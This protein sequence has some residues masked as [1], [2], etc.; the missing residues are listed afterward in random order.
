[1]GWSA[2]RRSMAIPAHEKSSDIKAPVARPLQIY[3]L[4]PALVLAALVSPAL[5]I[6]DSETE[7]N[8]LNF[9]QNQFEPVAGRVTN[10]AEG[11]R[12]TDS[13]ISVGVLKAPITEAGEVFPNYLKP[14]CLKNPGDI[15]FYWIPDGSAEV[16]ECAAGS[17]AGMA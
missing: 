6:L 13:P 17:Q 10:S 4:T 3:G 8:T 9:A 7:N 15:S 2:V 14:M 12:F 11:L 16:Q 1:M 5:L